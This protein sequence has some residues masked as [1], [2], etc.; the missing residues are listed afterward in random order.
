MKKQVDASSYTTSRGTTGQ[1]GRCV[2]RSRS[3]QPLRGPQGTR[4]ASHGRGNDRLPLDR[5]RSRQQTSCK[6]RFWRAGGNGA[7]PGRASLLRDCPLSPC[8]CLSAV[9]FGLPLFQVHARPGPCATTWVSAIWLCSADPAQPERCGDGEYR[10]LLPQSVAVYA[11]D[12]ADGKLL[13]KLHG[14]FS[15]RRKTCAEPC[16]TW[17]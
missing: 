9:L 8:L 3:D 2:S 7:C 6:D 15:V 10:D 16:P 14:A 17:R 1:G 12:V 4:G 11:D 13:R 5:A